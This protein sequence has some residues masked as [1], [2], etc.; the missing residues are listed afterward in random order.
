[1]NQS[2]IVL[3]V[4]DEGATRQILVKHIPWQQLGVEQV[5][6]AE[7]GMEGLKLARELKPHIIISD[8]KMPHMNGI[9]M[10]KA[11]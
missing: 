7:N 1:M 6:S 11:I 3:I 4:D 5:Y 10:A 2:I 9:E 8:I